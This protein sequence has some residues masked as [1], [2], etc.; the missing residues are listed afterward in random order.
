[1]HRWRDRVRVPMVLVGVAMVC[2]LVGAAG[3]QGREGDGVVR[4]EAFTM[5]SVDLT[6]AFTVAGL[7][8]EMPVRAGDRVEAGAVVARLDDRELAAQRALYEVRAASTLGEDLARAELELSRTELG[9]VR[10]AFEK[11]GMGDLEVKRRELE[12]RVAE[13]RLARAEQDREEAR[14]ALAQ[15]EAALERTVVRAPAAGVVERTLVDVGETVDRLVPVVRVVGVDPVRVE[16]SVP[17]RA[18]QGI[19]VGMPVEVVG[20][21]VEGRLVGAVVRVASVADAASG[22]VVVTVEAANPGG[23]GAGARVWVEFPTAV[24]AKKQGNAA[25]DG[26]E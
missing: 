10:E 13:I 19:A 15:A 26:V 18:A 17:L 12:V 7:V 2:A 4:V 11:G 14:L 1:M 8:A 5:P 23:V 22:T 21:D 6:L 20:I 9:R 16:A 25:E 24:G 3:A